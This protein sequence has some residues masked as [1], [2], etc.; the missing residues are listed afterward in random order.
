M[1]YDQARLRD[2]AQGCGLQASRTAAT[3]QRVAGLRDAD[4][5]TRTTVIVY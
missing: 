1:N 3:T 5:S 2:A 4:G